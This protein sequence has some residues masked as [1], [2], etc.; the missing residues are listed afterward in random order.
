M[1]KPIVNDSSILKKCADLVVSTDNVSEI[2]TDLEDTFK[3]LKGHGLAA[4]QIGYN[5]QIAIVRM[6]T[7]N[8]NLINPEII[9]KEDKFIFH[10]ETCFSFPGIP[11]DTDRYKHIIVEFGVPDD[12]KR[13]SIENLEA[14]VFQHEIDHLRGITI[15]DRKHRRR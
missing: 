13:V 5:K 9:S 7:C 12:R 2:I 15:L 6:P 1:K 4:N 10:G 3:E 8:V 14:V 11:I